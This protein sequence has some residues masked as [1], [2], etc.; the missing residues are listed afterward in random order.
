MTK[1]SPEEKKRE[2]SDYL[3]SLIG[4]VILLGILLL[5]YMLFQSNKNRLSYQEKQ[6]SHVQ[7]LK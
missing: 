1:L 3:K 4:I 5:G 7:I 2:T 6:K